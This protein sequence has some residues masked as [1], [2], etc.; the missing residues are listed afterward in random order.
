MLHATY[1]VA[2]HSLSLSLKLKPNAIKRKR[3]KSQQRGE[4]ERRQIYVLQN[5][6]LSKNVC[7]KNQKMKIISKTKFSSWLGKKVEEGKAVLGPGGG[8]GCSKTVLRSWKIS[9]KMRLNCGFVAQNNIDFRC[10]G[11]TTFIM[12]RLWPYNFDCHCIRPRPRHRHRL[13]CDNAW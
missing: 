7:H 4:G 1:R 5:V 6:R 11:L 3:W 13:L 10:D 8:R 2:T 12:M 9:A